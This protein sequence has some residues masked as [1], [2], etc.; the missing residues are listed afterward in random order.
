[1]ARRTERF[2]ALIPADARDLP[3]TDG[4]GAQSVTRRSCVE[5]RRWGSAPV[6]L[7]YQSELLDGTVGAAEKRQ[8][9]GLLALP[10]GAGK[11]VTAA[12]IGLRLLASA[13]RS[14]HFSRCVWLA[15]QKELLYQAAEAFER[16][17]W[18]GNG[19]DSLDLRV[20][21]SSRDFAVTERPGVLFLTPQMGLRIRDRLARAPYDCLFFDEAHHAAGNA[22]A[23]LWVY[24]REALKPRLALGLSATPYRATTEQDLEL[25]HAF[26][27]RILTARSLGNRPVETLVQERVLAEP[28]FR[29]IPGVAS[30]LRAEGPEDQRKLQTLVTDPERWAATVLCL[31]ELE[32]GRCVVFCLSRSHGTMLTKHLRREGVSAEYVD[33]R[34]KDSE[35]LAIFERFRD[36]DTRVLVS[37][38]LLIE[39][40][41]CP[42][43]EAALLTYPTASPTRLRQMIGRVL[44]GPAMGGTDKARIWAFEGNQ[45]WLSRHSLETDYRFAGWDITAFP[46]S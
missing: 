40:V 43:A 15:P 27:G 11:T 10:T 35:R 7:P 4:G 19:P 34:T 22:F 29:Q 39:G 6:P 25:R 41:D 26:D 30:Y 13:P 32:L 18:S 17:W 23:D 16:A 20:L 46:S 2:R 31:R 14:E 28:E 44:R 38:S 1:M 5:L 42:A 37:V 8:T 33:G 45:A 3:V 21:E 36:G 12:W 24:L 9:T